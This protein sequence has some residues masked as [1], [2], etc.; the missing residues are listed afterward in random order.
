MSK[1]IKYRRRTGRYVPEYGD[2]LSFSIREEFDLF[3][4]RTLWDDW[5][6]FRDGWRGTRGFG[7]KPKKYKKWKLLN[8]RRKLSKLK[9]KY[10]VIW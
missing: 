1:L 5:E 10:K 9:L 6:D 2:R 4:E 3:E 8:E 7:N